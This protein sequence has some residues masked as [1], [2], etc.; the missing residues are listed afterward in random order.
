MLERDAPIA[1]PY[2]LPGFWGSRMAE[3]LGEGP[4]LSLHFYIAKLL[5]AFLFMNF[6]ESLFQVLAVFFL[7][8]WVFRRSI[9]LRRLVFA[10]VEFLFRPF[11]VNVNFIR[12]VEHLFDELRRNE[13]DAFAIA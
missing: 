3:V 12:V 1:L 11:V 9:N 2:N 5:L 8:G 6:L 13:I 4:P 7:K 10:F